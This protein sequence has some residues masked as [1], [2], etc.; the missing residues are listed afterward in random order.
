MPKPALI[1]ID[2]Q[3]DFAH[4]AAAG[5]AFA[6]PRAVAGIADLLAAFRARD[7]PV[8]HVHHHDLPPDSPMHAGAPGAAVQ[9]QAAP[10]PGEP[11]CVKHVNSAFIGTSLEADLRAAGRTE[12]V[13]V[14]GAANY[15]VETTARMAGN[16]GFATTVVADALICMGQTGID[17]RRF[18]PA[19]VLAMTLAN[20]DG[21]FAR[22]VTA[23]ALLAELPA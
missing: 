13:L 14:G 16:L 20:F 22:V 11:V 7:L 6:N 15:C 4:R 19:D 5:R 1:V 12:L 10:L 2:V 21:E 8:I 17:G 3:M 23:A 18:P 9:P